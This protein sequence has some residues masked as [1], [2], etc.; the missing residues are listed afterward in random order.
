MY[1][2]LLLQKNNLYVTFL[3]EMG[4]TFAFLYK[5]GYQQYFKFGNNKQIDSKASSVFRAFVIPGTS[6]PL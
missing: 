4:V 6:V 2:F 1:F 5:Y 3:M